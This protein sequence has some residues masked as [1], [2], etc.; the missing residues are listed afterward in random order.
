[1]LPKGKFHI[2]SSSQLWAATRAL[3]TALKSM[4]SLEGSFW[5][6]FSGTDCARAGAGCR[7]GGCEARR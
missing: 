4:Q 3:V 1:M 7:E 6:W 2:P 5:A